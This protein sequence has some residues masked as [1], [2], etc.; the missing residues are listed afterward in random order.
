MRQKSIVII[1]HDVNTIADKIRH[2]SCCLN[3]TEECI[4]SQF[5][6]VCDICD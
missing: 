2:R 1:G 6:P 3:M 5:Q 4:T